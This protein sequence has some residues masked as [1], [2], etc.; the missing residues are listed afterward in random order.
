[1]KNNSKNLLWLFFIA[2]FVL[3]GCSGGGG[4]GVGEAGEDTPLSPTS[5]NLNLIIGEV[6]NADSPIIAVATDGGGKEKVAI[7]GEKDALGMPIKLTGAVFMSTS[8]TAGVLEIGQDGLP[9][10]FS[11]PSGSKFTYTNYT[12][13]TVEITIFDYYGNWLS[14]PIVVE[15]DSVKLSKIRANNAIMS[16]GVI[17]PNVNAVG[18][19]LALIQGVTKRDVMI[20]FVDAAS[21]GFSIASCAA[22]A[23]TA[24]VSGGIL[25][26][27]AVSSCASTLVNVLGKMTGTDF[28]NIGTFISLNDSNIITNGADCTVRLFLEGFGGCMGLLFDGVKLAIEADFEAPSNPTGLSAVSIKDDRIYLKWNSSTD[29]IAVKGYLIYRD[30]G[31]VKDELF[32]FFVDLDVT[33]GQSYCYYVVAYDASGKESSE[34]EVLCATTLAAPD[35]IPPSIPTGLTANAATSTRVN[36]S[37]NGSTDNV[38]VAGYKVYRDSVYVK[39]VATTFGSDPDLS[40]STQYCYTVTAYDGS[41]NES[42]QSTTS[43]TTTLTSNISVPSVGSVWPYQIIGSNVVQPFSIY[44]SNFVSGANITLRD[45]STSEVFPNLVASSFNSTQIVI[46]PI[47]TTT[48]A[49]WSVEVINPDGKSSGEFTFQVVAPAVSIPTNLSPG[50][51]ARQQAAQQ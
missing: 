28:S 41:G 40:L 4:D 33:P 37:W 39:S 10:S 46:N 11:D 30:D 8:G 14:G 16:K 5:P 15:I 25:T 44:G 1:M 17:R 12:A 45:K 24:Y 35:T 18:V 13:S 7:I 22:S 3:A 2:I 6:E 51:P 32:T 9:T 48:A 49:V 20:A 23:S 36:L 27:Y 38:E 47:F 21:V 19:K 50:A 29:N 26:A 34:S 42:D 31:L 43:C